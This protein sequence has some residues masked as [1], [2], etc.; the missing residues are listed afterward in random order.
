MTKQTVDFTALAQRRATRV[1]TISLTPAAPRAV[2]GR[3]RALTAP[4]LC[5]LPGRGEIGGQFTIS[6]VDDGAVFLKQDTLP[7]KIKRNFPS[8]P[9]KI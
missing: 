2:N 7:E 9:Q 4:Q 8:V 1:E 5:E 6:Y 3:A